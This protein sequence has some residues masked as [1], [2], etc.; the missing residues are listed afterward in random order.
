MHYPVPSY[1]FVRRTSVALFIL[2]AFIFAAAPARTLRVM[3]SPRASALS[4]GVLFVR[5]LRALAF[6]LLVAAGLLAPGMARAQTV[7]GACALTLNSPDNLQAVGC[8]VKRLGRPAGAS[9]ACGS[10][11]RFRNGGTNPMD[12]QRPPILQ[13][14]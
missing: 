13:R 4:V 3:L 14:F 8:V 7:G 2:A 12:R 10:K 9:R 1:G 6:V 11:L 5:K